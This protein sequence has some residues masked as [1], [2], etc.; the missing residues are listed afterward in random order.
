MAG[1]TDFKHI[2]VNPGDVEDTVIQA[3]AVS[4]SAA[5]PV[6]PVAAHATG[7]SEAADTPAPATAPSSEPAADA[8][9]AAAAA[10]VSRSS[11][12]RAPYRETTLEDIKGSKMPKTQI[13]VIALALIAI[14][15][16]IIWNV[17]QSS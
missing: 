16:F 2:T 3:G 10:A 15:A 6:R 5:H 12:D 11:G 7:A 13:I 4:S 14:A 1:Q 8:A 9:S 17:L